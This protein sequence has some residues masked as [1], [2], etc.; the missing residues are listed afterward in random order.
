MSEV[1][2]LRYVITKVKFERLHYVYGY[3]YGRH[4]DNATASLKSAYVYYVYDHQRHLLNTTSL[5]IGIFVA[6]EIHGSWTQFNER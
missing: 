1:H 5:Q 3:G 4:I 6:T 2:L